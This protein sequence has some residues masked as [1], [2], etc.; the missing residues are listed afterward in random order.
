M[1]VGFDAKRAFLNATGL[2]NYSRWLLKSLTSQQPD[3][4]YYLYTPK[5]KPNSWLRLL[6]S[7]PGVQ[8]HLPATQLFTSWWRTRSLVT[9]LKRDQVEIYH[10][11]SHELPLGIKGRGIATVVTVHDIIALRF[12]EYFGWLNRR[13]YVAKLKYACRVANAVVAISE[14]TK[15]D[16][17]NFLQVDSAKISVIYQN[18]D[19]VFGQPVSEDRK[20]T[21]RQQYNLP[22]SFLLTVGTIEKRKNLLLIVKALKEAAP[23]VPLVVVG[24]ATPYLEEVKAYLQEH[25]LTNRVFFLHQVSFADLPVMYQLAAVFIYPSRYEGFGIPVLEAL[26]SGVPVIAAAGSCLE[27]AGGPD[28]VY[29]HP[30]DEQDMARQINRLLRDSDTRQRMVAQGL[31]YA[32]KFNDAH[33]AGQMIHLYRQTLQH[34]A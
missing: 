12:P 21:V 22:E 6:S 23:A 33:L 27:E 5:T 31:Q 7:L 15:T 34:H 8:V 14:Q 4:Q 17:V 16:L 32:S 3:F 28:S 26:R 9:D 1:K 30:D 29:V 20:Q 24:K 18:C 19:E 2:G 11:L 10:G 13:I 25:H